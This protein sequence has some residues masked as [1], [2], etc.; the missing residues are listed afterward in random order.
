[1]SYATLGFIG[2]IGAIVSAK[3]AMELG[4]GQTRQLLWGIAG[5]LVPPLVLLI[6]YVRLIRKH[7][8]EGRPGGQL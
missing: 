1:M 4:F 8:A 2:V 6:L 7:K 5:L 3:W